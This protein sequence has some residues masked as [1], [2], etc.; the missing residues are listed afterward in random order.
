M[1]KI[2]IIEDD[3]SLCSMLAD[4]FEKYGYLSGV[5]SNF[6]NIEHEVQAF[7]PNVVL[8]DINLPYLDGFYIC[9]S[10]RKKFN[11]PIII[12]S[13]RNGEMEQVLG[14]EQGA[15][16]YIVKPFSIE[17]L[18]AKVNALMR[19]C[20]NNN[21]VEHDFCVQ[22]D[23]LILDG[24]NFT[25]KNNFALVELSKNEYKIIKLLMENKDKVVSREALLEALWNDQSFVD[26]N[27]LSVN[28]ARVRA[29]LLNLGL[30]DIIK[31]RKGLG[32]IFEMPQKAQMN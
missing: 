10:L 9:R 32:Y 20:R 24:S 29:R 7:L 15:D 30:E 21:S 16:D 25:L 3:N 22:L 12:I 14:M 28:M 8:L 18:L 2:F 31:T 6:R 1:N 4:Y 13:A 17:V 19:R 23:D 11:F 26:E 27:T 5:V